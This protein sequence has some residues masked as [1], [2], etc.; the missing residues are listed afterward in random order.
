MKGSRN[1]VSSAHPRLYFRFHVTM[2]RRH[3]RTTFYYLLNTQ[4]S[5]SSSLGPRGLEFTFETIQGNRKRLTK[6]LSV[7]RKHLSSGF[8]WRKRA[9][10]PL[11]MRGVR[12]STAPGQTHVLLLDVKSPA[13]LR[14]CGLPPHGRKQDTRFAWC[15]CPSVPSYTVVYQDSAKQS[16]PTSPKKELLD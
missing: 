5:Q 4:I 9:R 2:V 1:S 15:K 14:Q 6:H 13:Q 3:A 7:N 8:S 12:W 10:S 16:F 11:I